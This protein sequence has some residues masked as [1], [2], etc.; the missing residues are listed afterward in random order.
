MRGDIDL[1]KIDLKKVRLSRPTLFLV[2][3]GLVVAGALAFTWY[4]LHHPP[5]P[6]LMRW[7]LDRYLKK[8]SHGAGFK[9]DFP[10]P[11]K[12]DMAKPAKTDAAS[13]GPLKGSRTGKDFET[14]REEYLSQK[15]AA[16]VLERTVMRGENEAKASRARLDSLAKELAEA[17]AATD[18]A[19]TSQIQSN[20]V[21]LNAQLA[22]LQK[23]T[24]RRSE[25]KTQEDA[26]VPVVEDLWDFQ[27]AFRAETGA[28][29]G[30]GGATLAR[31]RTELVQGI[32]QKLNNAGSYEA[33]YQGIGQE[34]FVAQ[35]LLK[36]GRSEHRRQGVITALAASRQALDDAMNG[37]VAA[38]ICEGYILPHLDLATDKNQRSTFHEENLLGQ[39]ADIFRRNNEFHNVV[40]TYQIYLDG[41]KNPQRADWARSQIAM[42]YEQAGLAKEAIAAIRTIQDTNTYSRFIRRLPRLQQG[43][44]R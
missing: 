22:R 32:E 5:R 16:V 26:L 27:R 6:W 23:T 13:A 40:R 15:T 38:R 34:L 11:S 20:A 43:A 3:T 28:A 1:R 39:A 9:V 25:L 18:A 7:K 42:T 2:I 24:A 21:T 8:Q 12:T 29:E 33:M 36:S 41:V 44:G 31:A 37:Y 30:T 35:R 14:L 4:R 19:K 17:Q 10:F